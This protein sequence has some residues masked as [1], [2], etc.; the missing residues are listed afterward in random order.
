MKLFERFHNKPQELTVADILR[1]EAET[2]RIKTAPNG[3]RYK[4][5]WTVADRDNGFKVVRDGFETK[6]ACLEYCESSKVNWYIY[7]YEI[8]I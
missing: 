4:L 3:K 8:E 7:P 2:I 5:M 1:I 6:K